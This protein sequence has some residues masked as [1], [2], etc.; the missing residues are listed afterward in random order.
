MLVQPIPVLRLRDF[1]TRPSEFVQALGKAL[2]QFGFFALE[3]HG[4]DNRLIQS[5]YGAAEAF[6]AL[7]ESSK[8]HYEQAELKG[9]R[10]FTRFGKE[11][12]KDHSAPD[13]KE[14]WHV[15]RP[16]NRTLPNLWPKEVP[17]FQPAMTT[18]FQ[19]LETCSIQLLK[20]CALYLE[21]PEDWFIP[22]VKQGSSILRVIHYPPVPNDVTPQSM[23]A[24]P[25]EDI[26]LITLLCEATSA[27]LELL[28][29]NG[30][31]LP[32]QPIPGQVIVDTG[33]MLE[34][35]SNG[36]LKST[37]HRVTN[38]DSRRD[39]R[40]SMPFFVHPRP[41]FDLTPLPQCIAQTGGTTRFPVQS[42]GDYLQA[43]L[44]EIGL[45]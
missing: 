14:F 7:P 43:R 21:Q 42:A 44:R 36:L 9:Q 34:A 19:Q 39:R 11:H 1:S 13:L 17:Q 8:R 24:A 15:G 28:Q 41:S 25:H 23:R 38:P 35:L 40:F 18:L 27:G 2:A 32:I 26:N 3:D 16:D 37:T 29:T 12:A 4:I 45:A 22:E 33:D 5:A 20:A 31:W 30:E 10:G 6:F